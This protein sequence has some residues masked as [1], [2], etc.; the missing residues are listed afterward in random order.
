MREFEPRR[1]FEH[2]DRLAYEIGPRLA[3][4]R[5]DRMASDYIQDQFESCGLKTRVQ[6]FKF[7]PRAVQVKATAFLFTSAF[8][9][10][11]FLPPELSLVAWL[12]VIVI[13]RSL[14]KI[15][16]KRGSQNIIASAGKKKPKKRAAITAHYDSAP[17]MVSYK[18]YLF[19]KFAFLPVLIIV[20]AIVAARALGVLQEWVIVWSVLAIAFLPIC[21]GMFISASSR[22][23]SPGADDNA[24]GVAVMLEVARATAESSPADT[25]LTFIAFGAEEQGLVGAREFVASKALP[26][27]ALVLNLDGVGVGSHTYVIEGNGILRRTRTSPQLNQVLANSIKDA[28]LKP[29]LWWAALARH[30]HIPFVQAKMRATTY[31]TDVGGEDR[32]GRFIARAFRLPNARARRY[33]YIHT[34]EDTPERIEL[35]NIE[36]AGAVVLEFI[37]TAS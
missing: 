4:T 22:Q 30:D 7:V 18:L 14:G 32:L 23:V 29:R 9:A 31:T 35:T 26:E 24:S 16:P 20:T 25:E 15:M 2:L 13:W 17:C 8:I 3:G 37:K 19:L 5:G 21:I 34:L 1:A 28:G 6:G 33:R 10:L 11:L 36:R 12:A 27:D